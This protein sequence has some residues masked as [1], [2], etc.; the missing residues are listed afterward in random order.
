MFVCHDVRHHSRHNGGMAPRVKKDL[1]ARLFGS[2]QSSSRTS[3]HSSKDLQSIFRH[4]SVRFVLRF[5]A[6][7]VAVAAVLSFVVVPAS[8][9]FT[10]R[11]AIAEKSAEYDAL[12]DA[13]EQLQ[14]EVNALSTPEGIRNAARAQLGYVLPGEQPLQFVQM[15][16]LPTDL[17]D[18]W[19]YTMVTD[20]VRIQANKAAAGS[21]SQSFIP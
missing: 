2:Q 12:A 21:G 4:K 6:A 9:F 17:P 10:Q 3:K 14:I 15:P 5:T 20:I 8:R 16:A 1:L 11:S 18:E 19:P 7:S 13:N